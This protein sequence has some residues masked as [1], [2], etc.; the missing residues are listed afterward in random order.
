MLFSGSEL[1]VKRNFYT[2]TG[3]YGF[4]IDCTVDNTSGQYLFGLTGAAG[5]LEFKLESGRIYYNNQFIHSYKAYQEF[6]LEAQFTS[7]TY[8][9][10]K[11]NSAL[12]YGGSKSTGH[13][14][15]F[16]FKRANA[17]LGAEFNVQISGN[18]EPTYSITNQGYLLS[19]G[20]NAVTGYFSNQGAFP[21]NIFN[22]NIQATQN[23]TFGK[24]VSNINGGSSGSFAYSGNFDT[25]DI[26]QPILTTFNSN[27]NDIDMLFTI[28]DARSLNRFVYLTAPTDFTFN[29]SDILQRSVSYLNYSGGVPVTNY[30]ANLYFSIK[31]VSGNNFTGSWDLLTG[32]DIYSL[33]SLKRVGNFNGDT[34]SGS[35]LFTPNSQ[36]TMQII[37]SGSGSYLDEVTLSISGLEVLN[38]ITQNLY[39]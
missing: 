19:S 25:I 33:K 10:I 1:V 9:I 30:D 11:N 34:I 13:F 12:I 31:Y 17:S 8:N 6:S 36:L 32:L 21:I 18:N 26:S 38:P 5:T 39:N 23:Y 16:Y 27:Y 35:G 24:L 28:N 7:G 4:A 3:N 37:H 2:Q 20:Q 15:Y 14:D 22:S 29:D